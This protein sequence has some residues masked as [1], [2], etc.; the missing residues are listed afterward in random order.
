MHGD[1]ILLLPVIWP[2]AAAVLSPLAGR[3]GEAALN[4]FA[5]AAT[6]GALLLAAVSA[7]LA[8]GG[9]LTF[10]WGSFGG[11]G[12]HLKMDG[13]RA[14]YCCIAAFMWLAA[15]I[16][17]G[18]YFRGME[19][20]SRYL[21]FSLATLGATLGVFLSGDLSTAFLFFEL[22]SLASYAL[23]AHDGKP[24]ALRA[25]GVY[26]G[27]AV[28]GGL[29]MLMGLFLV[30]FRFGTLELDTLYAISSAQA[31]K[32]AL[33]LPGALLLIGFGA[34]AG[35]FPL[36]FWLPMAHPVAPAPASAL[37]SGVLTKTGVFGVLAVGVNMFPRDARWGF[38]LLLPAA[39]T[40][41]LGALLALC[42]VDMKRMLACSSV[43]QIGFIL[44]GAALLQI[45]GEHAALAARGTVLHMVNHSLAKLVLFLCAGVV[46]KK[47]HRLDLEGIRGF[48]RG[49][50]LFAGVFLTGALS[51]A[52]VPLWSGYLSKTLL[53]ESLVEA[54]HLYHGLP[55]AALLQGVEALFLFTGGLTA[56]Y[57]LKLSAVLF[58]EKRPD[59]EAAEGGG[60]YIG[61][62][63]AA[64]LVLSA[65][66]LPLL[67]CVPAL[68]DRVA[69]LGQ[70]FLR[71]RAP[72][73]AVRYFAPGNLLG[74]A[75][76]LAIGGLVYLLVVR[77]LLMGRTADE[78]CHYRDPMQ[79]PARLGRAILR[80]LLRVLTR[81]ARERTELSR[82]YAGYYRLLTGADEGE[83]ETPARE[84][85]ISY[86]L[87]TFG[88]GLG[89]VLLWAL[90]FAM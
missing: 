74:A 25:A 66:L 3:K 52:G 42:A 14:L 27:V 34:K 57:L 7:A 35:L 69:A 85:G 17:A 82:R 59:T 54:A 56:A 43:S 33:Y 61:R 16:S 6:G 79:Y 20:R 78:G 41:V 80:P 86:A 49:K 90:F 10:R 67:G 73:H 11:L 37:L 29:A 15:E 47:L 5:V 64:V 53:H 68:A 51:L 50:P 8:A 44:V 48:G 88:V 19:H 81:P 22:T 62:G 9:E 65:A 38:A 83:G 21:L 87:L 28:T 63:T 39:V 26:L 58:L 45:P 77:A 55:R 23:V 71:V 36:H 72:E 12:L 4:R 32:S 1:I 76:S 60:K 70:G 31:D 24:A 84:G 75:L 89:A 18:E 40:M 30:Q 46:Y 2:V 13:F